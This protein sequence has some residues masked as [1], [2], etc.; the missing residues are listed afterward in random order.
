MSFVLGWEERKDG[1]G[2]EHE[3]ISY[4]QDDTF[5]WGIDLEEISSKRKLWIDTLQR[6]SVG[7]DEKLVFFFK[8][9]NS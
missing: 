5:C 9:I 7:K 4:V 8:N 6:F 1:G 3:I 2:V